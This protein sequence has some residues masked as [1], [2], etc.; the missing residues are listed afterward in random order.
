MRIIHVDGQNPDPHAVD[1]AGA[2]LRAGGIVAFPTET[3]YGLGA[4]ALDAAAVERIYVAKGRPTYNPLIVHVLDADRAR[5]LAAEWPAMAD[6]LASAFWPGPLTLVVPKQA[7]IPDIVTAGLQS[8]GVR[9]PSHPVARALLAAAGVPVAAPSANRSMMLSPTRGS[10]VSKSLGEAVDLLL[11]AGPTTVGIESTV[12][13][14][15]SDPPRILRP[16]SI[17]TRQIESVIGDVATHA[18]AAAGS[19]ARLA[20]G[21]LDRHYAPRARVAMAGRSRAES[22][23]AIVELRG[24]GAKVGAMLLHATQF[25]GEHIVMMPDDPERYAA[26]LYDTMHALDDAGCDV[27]VVERVPESSAWAGVRDRLHRASH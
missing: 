20:P 21:M 22:E 17:S 8:F 25:T 5:A 9:V 11:D 26:R 19:G 6:R 18:S 24:T 16:G 7:L 2:L 23:A 1:E 12:L 27:I 10:H 14:L 15:T 4:N 13:D 3:V